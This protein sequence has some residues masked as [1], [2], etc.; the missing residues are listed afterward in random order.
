MNRLIPARGAAALAAAV[1]WNFLPGHLGGAAS[2]CCRRMAS[3]PP[4][5]APAQKAPPKRLAEPNA[6]AAVQIPMRKQYNPRELK[7]PFPDFLVEELRRIAMA[8][9]PFIEVVIQSRHRVA[10]GLKL[11][12]KL[13]DALE[14]EDNERVTS[15]FWNM[16]A[17]G[18]LGE[19]PETL[20][21][22]V[23]LALRSP[24]GPTS[25]P[26]LRL[27]W[28]LFHELLVVR[29]RIGPGEIPDRVLLAGMEIFARP[30]FDAA[31]YCLAV[32]G[33]NN[34]YLDVRW[35]NWTVLAYLYRIP[36]DVAMAG[37]LF[38]YVM[39][40]IPSD[41]TNVLGYSAFSEM[42][43]RSGELEQALHWHRTALNHFGFPPDPLSSPDVARYE[44]RKYFSKRL[45]LFDVRLADVFAREGKVEPCSTLLR[46]YEAAEARPEYRY[47]HLMAIR[48]LRGKLIAALINSGDLDRAMQLFRKGIEDDIGMDSTVVE[49]LLHALIPSIGD[50]ET[51]KVFKVLVSRF[52]PD[53]GDASAAYTE[54]IKFWQY[55]FDKVSALIREARTKRV[56]LHQKS[57][58]ILCSHFLNRAGDLWTYLTTFSRVPLHTFMSP[59]FR[60][61]TLDDNLKHLPRVWEQVIE[62]LL[63]EGTREALAA[64]RYGLDQHR[65]RE[66]DYLEMLRSPDFAGERLDGRTGSEWADLIE[67]TRED[68]EE[69]FRDAIEEDKADRVKESAEKKEV[70]AAAAAAAAAKG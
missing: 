20:L 9:P 46:R 43:L 10:D 24:R 44:P 28:A 56:Q 60:A 5:R 33:H 11:K 40:H 29:R 34:E 64:I 18:I 2:Q 35:I 47:E 16:A 49:P 59:L 6:V 4:R 7:I 8:P 27:A 58:A 41:A 69:G 54:A 57:L 37:R 26:S 68:V 15:V 50:E 23:A 67:K 63:R 13:V 3:K 32:Y 53:S 55:D 39:E 45:R 66:Q 19:V 12:R 22:E 52:A 14:T 48:S 62:R 51:M 42:I 17:L 36:N 31:L 65:S 21:Y 25:A 61:L 1:R 70:E 30:D 38:K